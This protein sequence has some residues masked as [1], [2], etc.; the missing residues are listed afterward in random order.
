MVLTKG[1]GNP[2]EGLLLREKA[3]P[4]RPYTFPWG[5]KGTVSSS[6]GLLALG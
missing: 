5:T 6:E 2:Y 3:A 4:V 1:L